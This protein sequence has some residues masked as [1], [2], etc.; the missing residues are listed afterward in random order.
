MPACENER[1]GIFSEDSL[2]VGIES[3]SD[4]DEIRVLDSKT[5][6]FQF[7]FILGLEFPCA[8][9]VDKLRQRL[10]IKAKRGFSSC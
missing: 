4:F 10:R 2:L 6:L 9:E 5:E 1:R 3:V 7:F 8:D